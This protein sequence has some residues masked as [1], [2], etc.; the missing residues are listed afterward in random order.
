MKNVLFVVSHLHSGSFSLC[1]VLNNNP[2]V[3]VWSTDILYNHPSDLDSLLEQKHK[4]LTSA[5]VYAD[6]LLYNPRLS[7][8][9]FYDF[10]KFIYMIRPA[11]PTMNMLVSSRK[12]DLHTAKRYYSF[13]LRRI[14]EMARNTPG[15]VLTT[16]NGLRSGEASPLIREYLDLKTPLTKVALR[17]ETS[18]VLDDS[19]I[20]DM[21]ECYERHLYFLKHQDLRLAI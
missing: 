16:W 4:N 6:H 9:C 2:R 18:E 8:S 3:S 12:Y 15:A 17:G 5:A 13:R 11:K 20:K 7:S 14:C 21:E 19:D 1:N 10:S